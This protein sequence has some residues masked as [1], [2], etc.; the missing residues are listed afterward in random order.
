[1][2]GLEILPTPL[3]NYI[4]TV[5]LLARFLGLRP[6]FRFYPSQESCHCPFYMHALA[7]EPYGL[8][9]ETYL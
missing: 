4:A 6:P 2:K 8:L 9:F 5:P 7:R 3:P 1:M